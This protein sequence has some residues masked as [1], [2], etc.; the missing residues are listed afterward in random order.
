[1]HENYDE[2]LLLTLVKTKQ[3]R[4]LRTQLD[5]MN[6]VDIAEFLDELEPDQQVLVFRLLPKDVAADVFT[7]LEDSEDQDIRLDGIHVLL[8]ED[9]DLNM[10]IAQ[11][12][13]ENAGAAVTK[14]W[15]GQEA[16]DC[17]LQSEGGTYDIILMD[18]MMPVMDG[19]DAARC[20]R[21]L[22]RSD[23]KSVPIFAITANAFSDDKE[24][25]YKAGMNE[26]IS[27]P[28]IKKDLLRIMKKYIP[29]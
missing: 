2:E 18:I 29:K 5:E 9:N 22:D 3:F 14:A 23:A 21:S 26:H 27:K 8:V 10:E 17:F 4:A 12:I 16:V 25:S 28:I 24:R 19:L 13:L 20:I 7:Y 11:F 6:E 15:N 1:M